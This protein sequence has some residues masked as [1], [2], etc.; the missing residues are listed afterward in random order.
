MT[1]ATLEAAATTEHGPR[2]DDWSEGNSAASGSCEVSDVR[3]RAGT[4]ADDRK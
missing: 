3:V 2:C 1:E 4:P